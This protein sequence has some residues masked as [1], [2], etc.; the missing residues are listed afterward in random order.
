MQIL[1]I[2]LENPTDGF[3]YNQNRRIAIHSLIIINGENHYTDSGVIWV[4]SY[5]QLP[6][7]S[8]G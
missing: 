5:L 3:V 6:D 1:K 8:L 2:L 4:N 7:N